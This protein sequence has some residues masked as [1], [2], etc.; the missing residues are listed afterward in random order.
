M[1]PRRGMVAAFRGIRYRASACCDL[2]AL[3]APPYDV[4]SEKMQGD[5]YARHPH[6]FIR[7]E[8]PQTPPGDRRYHAAAATLA[9]WRE[10]GVLVTEEAPSVYLLEQEFE[11]GGE[12]RRRRAVLCLVRLPEKGERYVLSHEGTLAAAKADRLELM[13]ACQAMTSP[14][15]LIREDEDAELLHWLHE[16]GGTPQAEAVEHD[17]VRDRLWTVTDETKI[18]RLLGGIGAGPLAIADGHH[19]FETAMAYRGEMRERHPTAPAE[20]EF[21]YALALV[22]SARDPALAILPTHRLIAG[23]GGNGIAAMK[24]RMREAFDFTEMV[25]TEDGM[26]WGAWNG[27]GAAGRPT[28]GVYCGGDNYYLLSPREEDAANSSSAVERLDVGVIHRLL[29]DPVIAGC[30]TGNCKIEYM[31]S[32]QEAVE[33][34]R[35]GDAEAA[36]LLRRTRIEDVL[37]VAKAGQRMPGKSTYFYPKAPAG[38]VLSSATAAPIR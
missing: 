2:S 29:I 14:V 17:G 35:R 34:V 38:L 21:N 26:K 8:L 3:I 1:E 27:G 12:T 4:I 11:A 16:V 36:I 25:L 5:L 18:R 9:K 19:R 33:R 24:Q 32:A 31:T 28:F 23:L 10:E 22:T 6:N 15:M 20:A 13:R 7:I 30:S 37:A